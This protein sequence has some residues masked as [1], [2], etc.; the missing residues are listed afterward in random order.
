MANVAICRQ[1]NALYPNE[2]GFS[3]AKAYPEYPFD[4]GCVSTT[5]CVYDLV[6][7]C[8][9]DYGADRERYGTQKWNPLGEWISPGDKVFIMP[10]FV[11]NRRNGRSLEEFN[12]KCT[13]GS[14]VRA[15]LDYASIA[16]GDPTLVS[17]GNAPLQ[18]CDYDK[19]ADETGAASV[20]KFYQQQVSV[21]PGPYD[22]RLMVANW[23]RFGAITK[24]TYKDSEQAVQ[25]DIAEHSLLE[26]LFSGVS[27]T[28]QVR[29]GDYPHDETMSYHSLGKH[30]YL[31]HRR[32]LEADVIISVPK[33]KTHQKVGITCALKGTVGSIARKECLAHHRQGSPEKGGDEFPAG[34]PLRNVASWLADK[35]ENG[36][37]DIFSN[38]LRI[39]SKVF[40]RTLR[41]GP[42]GIMGGAWY[43]N[44]TAWRMTL[45]IAR[46]LRYARIDGSLSSQ[47]VRRHLAF[48]DGIIAGEDEGPLMPVPRRTGTILFGSD[49]CAVDAACALVMGYAP[50]DIPLVDRSFSSFAFPITSDPLSALQL[51]LNGQV[52]T[53][54]DVHQQFAPAFVT[55]KGWRGK[56]ERPREIVS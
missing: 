27:Y 21:D 4:P 1:Q 31:I 8:L 41:F 15:I 16:T 45:D 7:Q 19:V 3:P 14:V 47:P 55:P 51:S 39:L 26:D 56:F 30:L 17:F 10:N 49:I 25:V 29:V 23:T 9:Y 37:T 11:M 38:L 32:A 6:R 20:A 54:M 28:P 13:H 43:G 34:S 40:H 48:V 12:A 36:R 42:S 46:I 52:V 18:A 22:L 35:V 44:D 53:W 50:Q 5:N 33:L 2:E 24:K